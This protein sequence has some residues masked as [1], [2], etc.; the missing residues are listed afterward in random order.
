MSNATYLP[1]HCQASAQ[2]INIQLPLLFFPD[3]CKNISFAVL[4]GSNCTSYAASTQS[5]VCVCV[6]VCVHIIHNME[7]L[8]RQNKLKRIGTALNAACHFGHTCHRFVSPWLDQTWHCRCVSDSLPA[9]RLKISPLK[10]FHCTVRL[11]SAGNLC[12]LWRDSGGYMS[13]GTVNW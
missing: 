13:N 4:F 11:V 6:C 7:K 2:V 1:S 8:V 5:G 3:W 12:S 9:Y 10:T